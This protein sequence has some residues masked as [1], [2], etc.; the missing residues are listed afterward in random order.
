LPEGW[1]K[2]TT[3]AA[4]GSK[5]GYGAFFWLNK[6]KKFPSAP[7]DMYMCEG[8][9]GQQIFILPTQELVVVVLGYSPMPV[10]MDCDRLLKD[11]LGTL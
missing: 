11:I 9:D 6:A 7:E 1:V 2:Y 3:T 4:S 8:H 5:N 10:G